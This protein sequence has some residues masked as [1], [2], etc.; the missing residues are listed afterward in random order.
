MRTNPQKVSYLILL[1]RRLASVH[2]ETLVSA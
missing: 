1:P 2:P